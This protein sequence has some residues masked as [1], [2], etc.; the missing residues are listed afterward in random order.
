MVK[1]ETIKKTKTMETQTPQKAGIWMDQQHAFLIGYFPNKPFAV[2]EIE[3]AI[4]GK[5]RF[6]GETSDKTR[7]M[8]SHG[9]SSNN[10][11][12]KNNIEENQL[13]KYFKL[14]EEKVSGVED[15][16]LMGPGITKGQ[17]FKQLRDNKKFNDMKIL[18]KDADK[19]T[20]NQLLTIIKEHFSGKN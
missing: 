9:G 12:K 3:S 1:F 15:L 18:L 7:F 10:E 6:E 14:L 8:N 11:N 16:L 20:F 17:F 2:E 13:R 5:V 19:M 4:E